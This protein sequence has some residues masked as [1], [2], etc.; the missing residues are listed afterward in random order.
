MPIGAASVSHSRP[1]REELSPV[2]FIERAGTVYAGR[3][4]V[5]DAG[6]SYTWFEFRTR[7]R[8][9]ASALR[10]QPRVP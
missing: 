1:Y 10:E 5:T 8:L 3:I 6:T 4:A 9:M 2:T 7:S